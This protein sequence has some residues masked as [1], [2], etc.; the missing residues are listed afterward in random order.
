L[1]GSG[2]HRGATGPSISPMARLLSA[3]DAYQAITEPRPHRPALTPT[4]AGR[5]LASEVE[6]GRLDREAVKA[7][8]EVTGQA[9]VG[10]RLAW[11]AN[12]SEREVQVLRLAARGRPNREIAELLHITENTVHHHVKRIYDKIGVATRAGAALFAME[13]G[14]LPAESKETT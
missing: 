12:L 10:R 2:Y 9:Q 6:N 14:L 11:P 7:V 13:H 4:V 8:L 3:A 1:N 5:E